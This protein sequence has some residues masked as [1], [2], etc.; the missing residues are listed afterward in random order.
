MR[1]CKKSIGLGILLLAVCFSLP[2]TAYGTPPGLVAYWTFDT[3]FT[4][5]DPTYDA[6]SYNGASITTGNK[7][8]GTGAADFDR[9]SSQYVESAS[10]FT[11]GSY[12]YVA[13]YYLD[14]ADITGSDRYF[15]LESTNTARTVYPAS[16]GLRESAGDKG[17]V[18]TQTGTGASNFM[19][20]ADGNQ[21]WHHIA[22]TY[23]SSTG[24]FN[25]YLDGGFVG[26]VTNTGLLLATD[27]WVLGGHRAGT[28]R[29]W[30][31][32]IDDVAVFDNVVTTEYISFLASGNAVTA[33]IAIETSAAQI[34]LSET[35]PLSDSYVVTCTQQPDPNVMITLTPTAGT[36]EPN[37]I[38][39]NS[40][41]WGQAITLT[42]SSTNWATPQTVTVTAVDDNRWNLPGE[43]DPSVP[44]T[45]MITYDTDSADPDFS[46][47]DSY[48]ID[49][50]VSILDDEVPQMELTETD[51]WTWVAEGGRTDSYSIAIT[52]SEPNVFPMTVAVVP[53]NAEVKL[54]GGTAGATLTLTFTSGDWATP[55]TVTI[56]ADDDGDAE[57]DH[58]TVLSHAV[59]GGGWYSDYPLPDVTVLIDDDETAT[60]LDVDMVMY[61]P[62]DNDILDYSGNGN[63]GTPMNGPTYDTGKTGQAMSFDGTNY[64]TIDTVADDMAGQQGNMT[65]SFWVNFTSVAGTPA[66]ISTHTGALVNLL[67]IE[68]DASGPCIYENPAY[69]LYSNVPV[70]DAQ[71]HHIAYVSSGTT[72]H[73]YVDGKDTGTHTIDT[74]YISNDR[75]SLAQEYDGTV[76]A[77]VPSNFYTGLMDD[78]VIWKRALS[79]LDIGKLALEGEEV[80]RGPGM[81]IVPSYI[82]FAV[83]EGGDPNTY[84]IEINTEPGDDVIITADPN[85]DDVDLGNGP[86]VSKTLTFT[87]LNWETPQTVTVTAVNDSSYQG[88]RIVTINHSSQS[89]DTDYEGLL[90]DLDVNVIDD[91]VPTVTLDPASLAIP[92]G[93]SDE[94]T[95]VLD[96]NPKV[97]VVITIDPNGTPEANGEEIN[98]GSG[99]NTPITLT[100][101]TSNWSTPQTVTV[102]VADDVVLEDDRDARLTHTPSSTGDFKNAVI[103]DLIVTVLED[104]CGR[105]GYDPMDFNKDCYID[106]LDMAEFMSEWLVCTQPYETGCVDKTQ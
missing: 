105:W 34:D 16:Y 39:L 2:G 54:N 10:P 19:F 76:E 77:P 15:V 37:D 93:E 52:G 7:K 44:H 58:A 26:S 25:G 81:R 53:D 41:N 72:A 62:L 65:W 48:L 13:W 88:T 73:L 82:P 46:N 68:C 78:V 12:T 60:G 29:N 17:N 101:T 67:M 92:E 9:A 103:D 32:Q 74:V 104:E 70:N 35:G 61:L 69:E 55:Q 84:T 38:K 63:D 71:W 86:G 50:T 94:Y 59:S 57:D 30:H 45:V 31:G 95:V 66:F 5:D 97:N 14:V 4:A 47:A 106:L 6:T 96:M 20:S 18:Y 36:G 91:D 75:W 23:D 27:L 22:V 49:V 89:S 102:T 43:Y 83:T 98:L 24:V 1:T 3:D 79:P 99:F 85:M 100:F 90:L 51:N 21:T 64:A 33:P 42:F 87:A 56:E 8:I 11:Q 40:G 80:P 28:G